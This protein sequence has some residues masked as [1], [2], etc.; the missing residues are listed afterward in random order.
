MKF[1]SYI[2]KNRW[3][4]GVTLRESLL[5]PWNIFDFILPDLVIFAKLRGL[6]SKF[7]F[8]SGKYFFLKKGNRFGCPRKIFFGDNCGLNRE[9]LFENGGKIEF[10]NNCMIGF[11]NLFI[12][13]SHVE[14]GKQ[15]KEELVYCNPIII[16]NNVWITSNCTILPGTIIE[17][18]V[19]LSAGS[20]ASG[21][22]ESGWIYSGNPA[23][24]IRK[25]KGIIL[26]HE[27]N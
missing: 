11:R 10:G 26:R 12:T 17:D 2:F 7:F 25:T 9:N 18:E 27:N 4:F 24:K 20:V 8:S 22:L 6:F 21:V 14:K 16:G 1:L 19:T 15:R 5:L 13:T 23:V 3:I